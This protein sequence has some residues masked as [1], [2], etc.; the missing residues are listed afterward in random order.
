[1]R[2]VVT[3]GAG[4]LGSHLCEHLLDRGDDVVAIDNLSTGAATNVEHLFG[5]RGFTFV[6]QDVSSDPYAVCEGA[7]VLTVL[8]EW[9]EFRWLD[10]AKVRSLLAAPRLVDA[11]NLLD[12]AAL[13]RLG[14]VYEGIG[15]A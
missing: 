10:F 1:M 13:R 11:R 5:R 8:T 3:G 9:D 15:R 4:F 2:I 7:D 6:E 14:F 12:P